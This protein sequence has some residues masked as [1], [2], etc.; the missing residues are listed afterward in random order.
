MAPD[1]LRVIARTPALTG[2]ETHEVH[3]MKNKAAKILLPLV[4]GMSTSLLVAVPEAAAQVNPVEVWDCGPFRTPGPAE[5]LLFE[6]ADFGG[7]CWALVLADEEQGQTTGTVFYVGSTSP[8]AIWNDAITSV[9]IGSNVA[10]ADLYKHA[11][12]GTFGGRVHQGG[13]CDVQVS[14]VW[15]KGDA[16]LGN[17]S[18][19]FD[20]NDQLSSIVF[21]LQ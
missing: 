7:K 2:V 14:G 17:G 12:L 3:T 11:N 5:V 20:F 10:Y 16:G 4:L 19:V 13:S 9:L 6:H 18:C 1:V 21:Q 15:M 8:V